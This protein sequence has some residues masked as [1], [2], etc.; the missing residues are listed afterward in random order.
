MNRKEWIAQLKE[1]TSD[2]AAESTFASLKKSPG[3]RPSQ[4]KVELSAWFDQLAEQDKHRVAQVIKEAAEQ[5]TFNFLYVLDERGDADSTRADGH[6][7]LRYFRDS[8]SILI[9]DPEDEPLHDIYNWLSQNT[10]GGQSEDLS[11]GEA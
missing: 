11:N 3:R 8:Q 9:N 7:E 1:K 4:Q 5:A 10:S 6:L 2:A